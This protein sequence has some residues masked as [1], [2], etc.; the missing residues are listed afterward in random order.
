MRADHTV[1]QRAGPRAGRRR[2]YVSADYACQWNCPEDNCAYECLGGCEVVV[3]ELVV[4]EVLAQVDES[5]RCA[6]E[7]VG[8]PGP[9][10]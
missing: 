1:A 7:I 3:R 8:A 5:L 9:Q 4:A 10:R 6:P 2:R